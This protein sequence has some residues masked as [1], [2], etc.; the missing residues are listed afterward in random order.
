MA[1]GGLASFSGRC[2]AARARA[3]GKIV[4]VDTTIVCEAP[5][6][7]PHR[8]AIQREIGRILGLAKDRVGVKATT[9]ERLGFTGRK[10]GIA[11]CHGGGFRDARR[12]IRISPT[13]LARSRAC[14]CS[15]GAR[16]NGLT[17]ATAEIVHRRH[18]RCGTHRYC[19]LV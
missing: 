8:D 13:H 11:H 1:R 15:Y 17:I 10:E 9:S 18:G 4:Q 19:R 3:G 14:K 5:K 16:A 6:I 2:R 7:G 12:E